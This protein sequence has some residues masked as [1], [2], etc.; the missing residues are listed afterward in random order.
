[1]KNTFSILI[2]FLGLSLVGLLALPSIPLK[3]Y[4]SVE[5]NSLS[6]DYSWRNASADVIEN[7][8]TSRLEG[9][10]AKVRGIKD[11]QSQSGKGQGNIFILFDKKLDK[12]LLQFELATLIRQVY[13]ELPSGV[14]FPSLSMGNSKQ[15]PKRLLTY[16]INSHEGLQEIKTYLD[17]FVVPR[18]AT[19]E[20]VQQ[21]LVS[22]AIPYEW[23]L[24]YDPKKL[25]N[26][27]FKTSDIHTGIQNYMA[28]TELGQC[29]FE[30][31]NS[32]NSY[33]LKIANLTTDTLAL[34]SIPIR[35]AGGRIFRLSDLVTVDFAQQ[36]ATQSFRINGQNTI[37]LSILVENAANQ[38]KLAA[39]VKKEITLIKASLPSH[40]SL[41]NSFDATVYL[42]KEL[43]LL[44]QRTSFTIAILLLFVFFVSR[45][46][47]YLFIISVS[48]FVNLSLACLCYSLLKVEIQLYS[49]AGIAVSTGIIID[50]IIIMVDHWRYR[51]NRKVFLAILAAT[52]TSIGALMVAFLFSEEVRE[53]LVDFLYV[54]TI[55]LFVSIVVTLFF[56]P[57]F[58][59]RMDSKEPKRPSWKRSKKEQIVR[60]SFRYE[61][62][63]GVC[64]RFSVWIILLGVLSFGTPIFALP[65]EWRG[66]KWYHEFYQKTFGSSSYNEYMRE[67]VDLFLG[68]T[69]RLFNKQVNAS[70]FREKQERTTIS[71]YTTLPHGAT[72]EQMNEVIRKY[73]NFLSQYSEIEQYQASIKDANNAYIVVYFKKEFED[74]NLPLFLQNRIEHI[75]NTI[76][77][78]TTSVSGPKTRGYSNRIFTGNYENSLS[79]KGYNLE[80]LRRYGE[81]AK[82]LLEG[83]LR[84]K[85]VMTQGDIRSYS[86]SDKFEYGFEFDTKQLQKH[87]L[88]LQQVYFSLSEQT[89]RNTSLFNGTING[90]YA[91]I[92]LQSKNK[93][94]DDLWRLKHQQL[95]TRDSEKK[96][97]KLQDLAKVKKIETDGIISRT[98]QNYHIKLLFDFNGPHTLKQRYIENFI[99]S[100]STRLPIGYSIEEDNKNFSWKDKKADF[101]LIFIVIGI[102]FLLTSCL[103]ESLRQPFVIISIIPLSLIGLFL[104][105]YLFEMNFNKGGFAAILLICG[106][107][108]NSVIYI[109]NEYNRL[110]K[111]RP[112]AARLKMYIK[113]FNRKII[114]ILITIFSTIFSLTPFLFGGKSNSFWFSLALGTIGG[115]LFSILIVTLYVPLFMNFKKTRHG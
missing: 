80:H 26:L 57:A 104:I 39:L 96:T 79:I 10:L 98:N 16:T 27:G 115:L 102:I 24:T 106:L 74:G 109:L 75:A 73:E 82:E 50:N 92:K 113:A 77:W 12:S 93:K 41:S 1:M 30:S 2:I 4:P 49:L 114:P 20:G 108:V 11:I 66:E 7:Q 36:K 90:I 9:L 59:S 25:T 110:C 95:T 31:E 97:F 47:K 81:Q 19:I 67:W 85:E 17:D 86:Y 15:G 78:A 76:G 51:H 54:F 55:N 28:Q 69:L 84:I 23:I 42:K 88:N 48:L 103:F 62:F 68:G 3:L 111:K 21:V 13:P 58:L 6:I 64:R 38:I 71:I 29:I 112:Y 8:V 5:R 33:Y 37:N 46:W 44:G 60:W 43:R 91:D 40:Y 56:I 53:L 45:S 107:T 87:Q 94:S 18:L 22:G 100:F 105:F 83:N 61:H 52:L 32:Q 101:N 99:A 72:I 14:S 89:N 65:L 63:L 35:T 70:P 34:E